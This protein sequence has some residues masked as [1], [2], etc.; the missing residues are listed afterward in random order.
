MKMK[1]IQ[2]AVKYTLDFLLAALLVL[3]MTLLILL[4]GIILFLDSPGTVFFRQLRPGRGGRSFFMWKLRTMLPGDHTAATPRNPD[5]S[6][7]LTDGVKG[8]TRF[9]K[10]LRRFSLDE[11]PQIYNILYGE[12]SFIGPRPDLPEHVSLYSVDE[13]VK[14]QVRPGMT[15]LAQ[16]MGRNALSWKERLKLDVQY[17]REYSLWLDIKIFCLTLVRLISGRGVYQK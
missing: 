5:G 15:G 7:A 11:L 17:V 9:G 2:L 16:V 8:Y 12:M 13:A 6:L 14:L 1:V 4:L 3:P 10:L